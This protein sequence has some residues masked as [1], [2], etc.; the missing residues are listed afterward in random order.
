[1]VD[2][3]DGVMNRNIELRVE[4]RKKSEKLAEVEES[5]K[6]AEGLVASSAKKLE[7][8]RAALLAC[9]REAKV[10]LD[11]VFAKAS[12]EPYA[13][14]PDADPMAFSMWLKAEVGQLVPLLDSVSDFGAYGA[15]LAV[16]CCFQVAGCDHLKKL[17]RVNHNFPSVEDVRGAAEHRACKNV[18]ARFLKKF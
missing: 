8:S 9:M 14:L 11:V 3:V 6:K 1:M 2:E 15:T 12:S 7:D 4:L 13:E 16:A 10:A 5:C 18:C 17:G